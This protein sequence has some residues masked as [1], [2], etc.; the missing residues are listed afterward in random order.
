M[1]KRQEYIFEMFPTYSV[2]LAAFLVAEGFEPHMITPARSGHVEY[3][4]SSSAGLL[5][6]IHANEHGEL[7]ARSLFETRDRLEKEADTF[8]LGSHVV[9]TWYAPP[10]RARARH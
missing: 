4:F 6:T 8:V 7:R 9:R 10:T 5:E 1:A 2:N 3:S